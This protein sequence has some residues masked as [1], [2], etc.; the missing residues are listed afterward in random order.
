MRKFIPILVLWLG[1]G[2]AGSEHVAFAHNHD[3]SILLEFSTFS[4][5]SNEFVEYA[6]A[7][8]EAKDLRE[9]LRE[10]RNMLCKSLPGKSARYVV[11]V[12]L[13][14][15][16]KESLLVYTQFYQNID[17]GFRNSTMLTLPDK[18]EF[19]SSKMESL[20][21]ENKYRAYADISISYDDSL[22]QNELDFTL[23]VV[24]RSNTRV[25]ELT[26]QSVS[27]YPF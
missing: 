3:L 24:A 23:R 17:Y 19:V 5:G 14:N 4:S 10:D 21:I 6:Y 13:L 2:I 11:Y 9:N 7:K 1:I 27:F 26:C 20:G 8:L 18:L 15:Y 12:R 22:V 25:V 16:T